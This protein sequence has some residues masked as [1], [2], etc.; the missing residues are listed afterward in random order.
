MTHAEL[1]AFE[2]QNWVAY[3]IGVVSCHG[4]AQVRRA[5]G[6]VA[7]LTGLPF[8][9]FNQ[10]LVERDGAR[11]ADV[12]TAVADARERGHDFVV[13]LRDG[14]DD[15][16]VGALS[17]AGLMSAGQDTATPGM[18]AFPIDHDAIGAQASSE[19]E[20]RRVT[21][22]SGIDAHRQVVTAGFGSDP[23]VADGTSCLK[24]LGR[25]ECT[26]YV[27]YADG[28]AV[29]SGLG[30]RTGRTI[31]VYSIATVPSA[32]RRGYGAAMTARVMADGASAGCDVAVLQAS[33]MGRPIY[34]RLG[35]RTV[36]NYT[37]YIV[38]PGPSQV[39]GMFEDAAPTAGDPT[40]RRGLAHRAGRSRCRLDP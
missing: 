33:D 29:V 13:R 21:G 15:R 22:A 17:Q 34:E 3:L 31:G 23:A 16:F 8:D 11:G 30:W 20:I 36:V 37:A 27:G 35:F 2:H 19:L 18:V 39:P 38:P 10:I 4:R 24:L 25:P 40:R 14:T 12:L 5:G 9:W 6:V 1:V 28:E 32:R 7:I 26:V